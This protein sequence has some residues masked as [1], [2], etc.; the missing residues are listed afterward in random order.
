MR[1][2]SGS[3]GGGGGA[4]GGRDLREH[5]IYKYTETRRCVKGAEELASAYKHGA[6][7][8]HV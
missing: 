6:R 3:G 8:S 5:P 4:K 7:E 2:A 1:L